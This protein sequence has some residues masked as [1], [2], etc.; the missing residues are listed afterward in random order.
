MKGE[1]NCCVTGSRPD[2]TILT[3]DTPTY[4][5]ESYLMLNAHPHE[6]SY[7]INQKFTSYGPGN[8][9]E[10]GRGGGGGTVEYSY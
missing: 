2:R 6:W 10:L 7:V 4:L 5:S 3:Y 8:K 1:V 9:E